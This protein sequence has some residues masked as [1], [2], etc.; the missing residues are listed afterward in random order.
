MPKE[1]FYAERPG[2]S[3]STLKIQRAEQGDSAVYLCASSLTT[4]LQS[5]PL[6]ALKPSCTHLSSELPK[7]LTKEWIKCF[8]T[9]IAFLIAGVQEM[10]FEIQ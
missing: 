8:G 3:Y 7:S 4:A 6:L 1:R 10:T 5:H 2:G 9:L